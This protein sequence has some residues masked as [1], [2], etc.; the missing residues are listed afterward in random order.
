MAQIISVGKWDT[1]TWGDLDKAPYFCKGRGYSKSIAKEEKIL[2][3]Y[4]SR[5]WCTCPLPIGQVRAHIL[6]RW[7]IWNKLLL[8]K[9]AGGRRKVFQPKLEHNG[10]RFPLIEKTLAFHTSLG[11][12]I[13]VLCNPKKTHTHTKRSVSPALS[14]RGE[15]HGETWDTESLTRTSAS[16]LD[17]WA[18]QGNE[19]WY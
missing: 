3:I 2:P 4:P 13:Y 14:I 10:V 16:G 9:G 12:S 18:S 6:L 8:E 15:E 19:Y 1:W 5:R 11:T 7:L 17:M